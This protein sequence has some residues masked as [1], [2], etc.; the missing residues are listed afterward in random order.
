[1]SPSH[2]NAACHHGRGP[3]AGI[4]VGRRRQRAASA[5]QHAKNAQS[6]RGTGTPHLRRQYPGEYWRELERRP[7]GESRY[8]SEFVEHM[9]RDGLLSILIPEEY[10]G[11]GQSLRTACVVLEV[12]TL[13]PLSYPVVVCC[14]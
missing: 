12:C 1:M 9:Q 6:G 14:S 11:G 13:L 8:P 4:I 2:A 3:A 5:R 7:H 10:G